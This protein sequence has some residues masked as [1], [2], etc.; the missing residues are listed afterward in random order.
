MQKLSQRFKALGDETRLRLMYLL[1][2]SED[3]LCVCE[4]MDALEL[5]QYQV[6]R[7]LSVLKNVGLVTSERRGTWMYYSLESEE[8]GNHELFEFLETCLRTSDMRARFE[9]DYEYLQKRI[10]LREAGTCVVGIR[11]G[12]KGRSET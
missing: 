1:I 3:T 11:N 9:K 8:P 10:A 6:S 2:S 7:H 12:W 4:M 5:P